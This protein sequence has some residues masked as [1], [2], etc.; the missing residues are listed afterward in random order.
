LRLLALSICVLAAFL[1]VEPAAAARP[2]NT[3]VEVQGLGSSPD[4]EV[5]YSRVKGVGA[6][7]IRV[8]AYWRSIETSARV[9]NWSALDKVVNGAVAAGLE[10]IVT[11]WQAPSW[12]ENSVMRQKLL[13]QGLSVNAGTV[14]PDPAKFAAFATAAA[15]RYKGKVTHWEAW[16]EPN[17]THFLAPQW[18]GTKWLTPAHYRSMVNAFAAAVHTVDANNIVIAGATA[19]FGKVAPNLPYRNAPPL[20][21]MRDVLCLSATNRPVPGCGPAAHF[22]AW[23]THPYTQGGPFHE[24]TGGGNVSLGDLPDMKAVLNAGV[25]YGRIAS[26]RPVNFWVGE[27]GWDSYLPDPGGLGVGLHARWTAEAL[28]QAWRSGVSTFVWHQLND[29]P[30]PATAYQAGLYYC[31]AASLSDE[32]TCSS[33]FGIARAKPARLSF[34][35]PFVAYARSGSN[36]VWGRTP[37]GASARVIIQRKTAYGWRTWKI[38]QA[39]SVGIFSGRWA[40]S[41]TRGYLRAGIA[42]TRTRSPRFSLVQPRDR[43]VNPF[44]S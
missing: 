41:K 3:G 25:R 6:T 14:L 30:Y 12:A 8:V 39:N 15:S 37:N 43:F 24:A 26:N 17:L 23:S 2:L 7:Y 9:Y 20:R 42:G 4:P 29:R 18:D 16:N 31:G 28:Y 1:L 5:A 22:D 38:V 11:I 13:N 44:G 21:F 27:F 40:S 34:A 19:P 33:S 36:R 10:P 35:F 32:K